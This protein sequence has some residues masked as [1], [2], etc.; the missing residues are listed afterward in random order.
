MKYLT[1]LCVSALLLTGCSLTPSQPPLPVQP[2]DPQIWQQQQHQLQQLHTWQ[3][4][5]KLGVRTPDQGLSA[6]LDWQ[7]QQQAYL[8]ELRGPLGQGTVRISG[9]QYYATLEVDD[10]P[11]LSAASAQELLQLRLDWQL[12]VRQALYWI[13][14]LPAPDEPYAA[15][16]QDNRLAS[17]E[18]L[19]WQIRY[20]RYQ[21]QGALQLPAKIILQRDDL[22]LTL[23]L[24]HWQFSPI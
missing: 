23:V 13:K 21:Q 2:A 18:Q 10:E 17:L 3:V 4:R 5:G 6:S 11:P 9:D 22:T 15:R 16:F 14:G 8:I 19:G 24:H 12:P 20:P 7:Q 1:S